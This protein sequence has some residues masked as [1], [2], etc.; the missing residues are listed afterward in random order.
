MDGEK[1]MFRDANPE[2]TV[3]MED[4]NFQIFAQK[5]KAL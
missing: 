2:N 3:M 1:T 4:S 5:V